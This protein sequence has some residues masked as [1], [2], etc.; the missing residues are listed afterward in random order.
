[1]MLT[2]Q[3]LWNLFPC[4]AATI[5]LSRSCDWRDTLAP[6][7]AGDKT[8]PQV[9]NCHIWRIQ[10]DA[11]SLCQS[12]YSTLGAFHDH[13]ILL[14]SSSS[15]SGHSRCSPLRPDWGSSRKIVGAM[16]RIPGN[17]TRAYLVRSTKGKSPVHAAGKCPIAGLI[18]PVYSCLYH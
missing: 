16:G 14:T 1:M 9:I 15:S 10:R 2:L 3:L 12:I 5:S 18:L 4:L 11:S 17:G 8:S 13:G 6:S 7:F